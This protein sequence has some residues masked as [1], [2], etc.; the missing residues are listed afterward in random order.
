[1][2]SGGS[3]ENRS[4]GSLFYKAEGVMILVDYK[5]ENYLQV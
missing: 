2:L 5:L 1:M 3:D 4:R